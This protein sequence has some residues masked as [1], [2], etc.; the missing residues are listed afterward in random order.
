M[1]SGEV[2][3]E[4]LALKL[5]LVPALI[6]YFIGVL[7]L[8]ALAPSILIAALLTSSGVLLAPRAFPQM[9]APPASAP[10]RSFDVL[11]RMSIGAMLVLL[12]THFAQDLGPRLSGLLAMFPL[13]GSVL[14]VFSQRQRGAAFTIKLLRGMVFGYYAFAAFCLVLALALP[15]MGIAASFCLALACAALVQAM[16]RLLLDAVNRVSPETAG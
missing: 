16:S 7:S 13:L 5:L 2:Q 14:A 3:Y 12:L 15:G 1:I 9:D 10:A 11:L 6:A 4:M 8:D